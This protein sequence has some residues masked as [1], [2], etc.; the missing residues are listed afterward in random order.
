M[1][2]SFLLAQIYA[3]ESLDRTAY[4][5]LPGAPVRAGDGRRR[6]GADRRSLRSRRAGRAARI[7]RAGT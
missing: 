1:Q 3:Q 7:G 4:S 6:P 5:A 2:T